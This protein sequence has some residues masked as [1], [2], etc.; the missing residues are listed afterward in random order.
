MSNATQHKKD[1]RSAGVDIQKG[2]KLLVMVHGRGGTAEDI[3]GL[4]EHLQ[5]DS[6]AL[7]APQA[8]GNTW[9]PYSFMAPVSANEPWLSSAI[10][11]LQE[12]VQDAIK[13]GIEE[14]DIY[15]LGFS[16]GACLALEFAARHAKR[17]GGVIAFTGGLIGKDVDRAAYSGKFDGM[18]V[19]IGSS[20][21]DPHVPVTRVEETE[22]VLKEMGAA[23]VVKI[24]NGMGHTINADEIEHAKGILNK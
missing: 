19:F 11:L 23:V 9:Y 1:I 15:F 22:K 3:L 14:K 2:K 4:A 13:S 12:V 16:Q 21:P 18:P 10:D 24:Y 20:N 8:T 17:Y 7:V 6:F 5:A